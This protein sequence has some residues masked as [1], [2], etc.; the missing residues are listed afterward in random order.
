MPSHLP[1]TVHDPGVED[2]GASVDDDVAA[3]ADDGDG[4]V[5]RVQQPVERVAEGRVDDQT[6][7]EVPADG[8]PDA[9]ALRQSV[10]HRE[11][12]MTPHHGAAHRSP[13]RDR[14]LQR[15]EP[16]PAEGEHHGA[17]GVERAVRQRLEHDAQRVRDAL[18]DGDGDDHDADAAAEEAV[19]QAENH[20]VEVGGAVQVGVAPDGDGR[21][22]G[23]DQDDDGD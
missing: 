14:I 4:S 23:A 12:Q 15:A 11:S 1:S 19:Q 2:D 9:A 17:D 10:Q 7:T 16:I 8:H 3:D 5:A 13:V 20:D 18:V 22:R 6:T 21:S